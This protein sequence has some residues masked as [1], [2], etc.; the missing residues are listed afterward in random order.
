MRCHRL[1]SGILVVLA[2]IAAF[3]TYPRAASAD[4][5]PSISV[6]IRNLTDRPLFDVPVTFGQVFRKGDIGAGR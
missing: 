3:S 4:E 2:A 1:V 5:T 6:H